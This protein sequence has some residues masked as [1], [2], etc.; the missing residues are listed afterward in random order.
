MV[1]CTAPEGRPAFQVEQVQEA[2]EMPSWAIRTR[3]IMLWL[4][5]PLLKRLH[6][7]LSS[8]RGRLVGAEQNSS[9]ID[10]PSIRFATPAIVFVASVQEPVSVS[11]GQQVRSLIGRLTVSPQCM[12]YVENCLEG[13]SQPLAAV[14][15]LKSGRNSIETCPDVSLSFYA[16]SSCDD[17]YRLH[18][19]AH[20]S[21][22]GECCLNYQPSS[23]HINRVYHA[24]IQLG[25]N[26]A[27]T[28]SGSQMSQLLADCSGESSKHI[29]SE[30]KKC[31]TNV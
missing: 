17:G 26:L 1:S 29:S 28:D 20:I 19:L 14:P 4:D 24:G 6:T 7:L 15:L 11:D 25:V 16:T 8:V 3:Q 18:D 9:P 21:G 2:E 22:K 13:T 12:A 27:D 30:N 31:F 5:M 23:T 10:L